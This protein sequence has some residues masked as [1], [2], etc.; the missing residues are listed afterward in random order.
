MGS[1]HI[2]KTLLRTEATM[3]QAKGEWFNHFADK[4][5]GAKPRIALS[6]VL[7]MLRYGLKKALMR[8]FPKTIVLTNK[9]SLNVKERI[10]QCKAWW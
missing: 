7:K 6:T 1:S 9:S 10:R 5:F 2:E 3:L 4:D 8:V